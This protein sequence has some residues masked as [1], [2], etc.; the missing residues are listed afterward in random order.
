M[1][2]A[3]DPELLATIEMLPERT[4]EVSLA[5]SRRTINELF[6]SLIGEI[7]YTGVQLTEE[8]APGAA[9]PIPLRVFTPEV[10]KTRGAIY[11]IHGGGFTVGT[12]AMNDAANIAMARTLGAVV[13]SVDYRLAPE[14]P[15]PAPL[16][17]CY[18]GLVWLAE[19]AERLGVDADTIAIHGV[20]AG[21]GLCAALALLARD[22]GGPQIVFQYLGVP[23]LDDRLGTTSMQS[24]TDTPLWNLPSAEKSWAS[25]LGDGV[26]GTADVSPY[27]APARATN[28]AGLPPAYISAMH[29]DP[30]RDEDIAYAQ[31]LLAAGVTVELHVFPGTFHGSSLA[32]QAAVSKREATEALVVLGRAL[33]VQ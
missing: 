31:A 5:E 14:N 17:D 13:V 22:R 9:G 30:L 27:A 23:E 24:F 11:D 25:Y 12:A 1:T 19:Q 20:S 10:R 26:P 15:F 16:D 32:T 33:N 4:A 6:A 2:Y 29:F 3:F 18:A 7:D 21:G 28:L 8:H